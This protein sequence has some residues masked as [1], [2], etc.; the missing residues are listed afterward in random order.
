MDLDAAVW[1]LIEGYCLWVGAGVTRQAAAGYAS[2]PLWAQLTEEMESLADISP[3]PSDD[4]PSRLD[5]CKTSL[6]DVGFRAFLRQRYCTEMAVALLSQAADYVEHPQFVPPHVR[7]IAALGQLANPIVSF[8]VESLSSVLLGRPGGPIRVLLQRP[9]GRPAYTWREEG[10]K[11]QRIVYHPHGLATLAT[12]MTASEYAANHQTL[13]FRLAIHA[14][15]GNDLVIAGMSLDDE[16]L[17]TQL[18][19]FRSSLAAIYWFDSQFSNSARAWANQN[20]ITIVEV[21]WNDFWRYWGDLRVEMTQTD[22]DVAW[23]LAISQA[24]EEAAG[25]PFRSL[26]RSAGNGPRDGEAASDFRRLATDLAAAGGEAGEVGETITIR[27]KKPHEI[28]LALRKRL[29]QT[30]TDPPTIQHHYDPGT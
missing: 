13:A 10:G 15:F 4:Y 2:V 11:F 7:A 17:R 9:R 1:R 8:N 14:G 20:R 3:N 23:H 21:D 22:L 24:A 29:L 25:G 19:E 26:L 30:G 27:G 5:R 18:S 6:G 16:Y 12:A 28:E